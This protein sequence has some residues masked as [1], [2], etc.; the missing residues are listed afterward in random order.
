MYECLAKN[1]E[2]IILDDPI[3]SFD[4][5]K[6]YAILEM[7]FRK[8]AKSCLKGKTVLMLTHDVEPIIDTVKAV[9]SQFNNQTTASFL[10]YAS[11]KAT[12]VVI[13]KND[14]QTFS[15]ICKNALKSNKDDIIKAIYLRRN[16]EIIDEKGDGY[17]I[18]SNFLHKRVR[19]IDRRE[20]RCEDGEYPEMTNQRFEAGCL[21]IKN[22]INSFDYQRFV[23]QTSNEA[24]LQALYC[25]SN[26]GY[27]KLQLF[28]LF[29]VD[30]NNS[31]IQKFINETYHIEN[32]FISQL[33]PDKFDTIPA[34]VI[35]ECNS[36]ITC[37]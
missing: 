18:L 23:A 36:H 28:R 30:I 9:A 13:E 17:Q 29:D 14:I 11:G 22:H 10:R 5:N 20:S 19:A 33:N 21:E 12:E 34:Y 2:L 7:L 32:E 31:V 16:L 8:G 1:P 15:E 26:N 24:V 3:S 27:E 35:E 37:G 4:K 25:S 6:K